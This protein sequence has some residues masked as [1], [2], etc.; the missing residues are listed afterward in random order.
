MRSGED[1]RGVRIQD[2]V[3]LLCGGQ[4]GQEVRGYIKIVIIWTRAYRISKG[5][6][7]V[8]ISIKRRSV[9]NWVEYSLC[10]PTCTRE[11]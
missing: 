1:F 7:S 6:G 10:Q 2:T 8:E 4:S 9:E 11:T 5:T 3:H